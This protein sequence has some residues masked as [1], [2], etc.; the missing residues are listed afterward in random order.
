MIVTLWGFSKQSHVLSS[1]NWFDEKSGSR[2]LL[3]KSTVTDCYPHWFRECPV[4]DVTA[5]A[6][7]FVNS[8][9]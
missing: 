1:E 6:S 4:A 8:G 9:H 5:Q 7:A 2:Y 3:A